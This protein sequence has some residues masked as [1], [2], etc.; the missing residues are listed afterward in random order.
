MLRRIQSWFLILLFLAP[1][2]LLPM[3]PAMAAAL[4]AYGI[5]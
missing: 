1:W 3:M 5:G 4:W 2:L